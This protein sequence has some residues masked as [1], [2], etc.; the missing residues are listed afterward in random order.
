[1]PDMTSLIYSAPPFI[2]VALLA[3]GRVS[4]PIQNRSNH[5]NWSHPLQNFSKKIDFSCVYFFKYI[6]KE[7]K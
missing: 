1:M 6:K 2:T 4:L 7:T 3:I 5:D